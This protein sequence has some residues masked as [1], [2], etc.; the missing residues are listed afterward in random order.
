MTSFI[1]SVVQTKSTTTGRKLCAEKRVGRKRLKID[2][3]LT[4]D[5]RI[6][7][8][9]HSFV[10][11]TSTSYVDQG[12]CRGIRQMYLPPQEIAIANAD[13]QM[14]KITNVSGTTWLVV[15]ADPCRLLVSN[16]SL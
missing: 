11:P 7:S 1:Q 6:C 5:V 15:M 14:L 3:D 13:I 16:F 4:G 8:L 12:A 2:E 9:L 10:Q